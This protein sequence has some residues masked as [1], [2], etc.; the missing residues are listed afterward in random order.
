MWFGIGRLHADGLGLAG[1]LLQF[2]ST[3]PRAAPNTYT[4]LQPESSRSSH[5]LPSAAELAHWKRLKAEEEVWIAR[6]WI[7]EPTVVDVA[8]ELD[9]LNEHPSF[10][11]TAR[12]CD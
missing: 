8:K 6:G 5:P 10:S 4:I 3:E 9:E 11:L 2:R 1:G 7:P 12:L